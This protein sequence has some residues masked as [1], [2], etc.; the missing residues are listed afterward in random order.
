[1]TSGCPKDLAKPCQSGLVLLSV[2]GLLLLLSLLASEA[3]TQLSWGMQTSRH[4]NQAT[5]DRIAQHQWIGELYRLDASFLVPGADSVDCSPLA[6]ACVYFEGQQSS[7]DTWHFV[8]QSQPTQD[9]AAAGE[10]G[11]ATVSGWLRRQTDRPD[12]V[13][14]I[15]AWG[16]H[17]P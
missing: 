5:V 15:W 11:R 14:A 16:M 12:T 6:N 7:G 1:M 9:V 8:V 13:A 17:L 4:W 2:I 10:E 3:A